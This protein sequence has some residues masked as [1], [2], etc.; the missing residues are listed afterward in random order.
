MARTGPEWVRVVD[1]AVKAEQ[2]QV[3]SCGGG[4]QSG[5]I[6]SLIRLG[7]LPRPDVVFMTDTGRERSSTWP[8]VDGFIRPALAA[9]GLELTVVKAQEFA[10]LDIYRGNTIL[11]PGFTTQSGSVGKLSPFCSGKWKREVAERWMRSIGIEKARNWIGISRDEARRIRAQ[12]QKWLE[13]WYPLIFEVPMRREECV[14]LIRDQ[15][16]TDH[17]PHSACWMCPNHSDAEW[18]DMKRH[19]PIDFAAACDLEAEVRQKDS[20]FYLH[21]SCVPLGAV[22]FLAQSTMFPERGC[23]EGCFT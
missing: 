18:I 7:K 19:W 16:W 20:H 4:T 8:F 2:V 9:V 17:I 3:W 11:L 6:A 21:Q 15:G 10:R 14:Q 13:L 22:D 23:M 5:A 12:S 1:R